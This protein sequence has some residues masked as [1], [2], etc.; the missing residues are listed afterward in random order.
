[1]EASHLSTF[2][3]PLESVDAHVSIERDVRVED[4]GQK[5]LGLQMKNG[6]EPMSVCQ[7]L[8]D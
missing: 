1:M 8:M 5:D 7:N 4:L 6:C 3:R 2:S